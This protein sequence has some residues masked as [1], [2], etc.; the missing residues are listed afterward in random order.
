MKKLRDMEK[1]RDLEYTSKEIASLK[2]WNDFVGD[3]KYRLTEERNQN[4]L[5][6][7]QA[8]RDLRYWKAGDLGGWIEKEENLSQG[9]D[10]WVDDNAQVFGNASII[11][12]AYIGGNAKIFGNA[13]IYGDTLVSGNA[14]ISG[15]THIHQEAKIFGNTKVSG[16]ARVFGYVEISGDVKIFGDARVQGDFRISTKMEINKT[17][18]TIFGF[19]LTGYREI[20]LTQTHICFGYD[21]LYS[22]EDWSKNYSEIGLKNKLNVGEIGILVKLVEILRN[23]LLTLS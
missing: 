9:G 15:E 22:L 17:P 13:K 7:I 12:G 16:N 20:T 8:L 11:E 18:F 14:E 4:G 23:S 2:R 19:G 5:F 6:R 1:L 10:C 21:N 3:P